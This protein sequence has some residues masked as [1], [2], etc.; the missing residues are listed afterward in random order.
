MGV[1]GRQSTSEVPAERAG[2]VRYVLTEAGDVPHGEPII[3]DAV[4]G[5]GDRYKA[6]TAVSSRFHAAGDVVS[7]HEKFPA[8]KSW[9]LYEPPKET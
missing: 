4:D 2:F 7:V 8:A 6:I 1:Y 3:K 5:E 9:R